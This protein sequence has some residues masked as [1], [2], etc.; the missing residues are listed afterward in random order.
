MRFSSGLLSMKKAANLSLA[1]KISKSL[2]TLC[3]LMSLGVGQND[4]PFLSKLTWSEST[5]TRKINRIQL[6]QL[7]HVNRV[8]LSVFFAEV[9][10][11]P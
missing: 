5:D 8:G 3:Q 10:T 7:V 4:G 1:S 6:V 2:Y 9:L 11:L